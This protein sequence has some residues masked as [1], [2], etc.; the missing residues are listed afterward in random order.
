MIRTISFK[1]QSGICRGFLAESVQEDLLGRQWRLR[2]N[3][4]RCQSVKSI[5]NICVFVTITNDHM[6]FRNRYLD[7]TLLRRTQIV[8]QPFSAR[9]RSFWCSQSM[10]NSVHNRTY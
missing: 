1:A 5:L 4:Q 10:M 8:F 2:M 9:K 6:K 3:C 7:E